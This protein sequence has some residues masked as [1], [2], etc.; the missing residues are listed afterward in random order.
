MTLLGKSDDEV[1]QLENQLMS[2]L[3]A[4]GGV[5]VGNVT[6][7]RELSWLDE[8]YW[9]VR[10]RLVDQ[11][12][13]QRGHGRGGSV[14]VV[15]AADAAAPPQEPTGPAALSEDALYDPIA[16]VLNEDWARDSRFQQHLVQVT[17]KQGRKKTGGT[18]TRPDIIVAALRVFPYLPGKYFDLIS[19]E[20]K[21]SWGVDVTAVYE[22]LAHR[23]ASTQAYTWFHVPDASAESL[24]EAVEAICA[25]A[26]RHGVGVIVASEPGDYSTWD[27]MVDADRVPP[28]PESTNELVSQLNEAARASLALWAR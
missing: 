9:P 10:D 28:D 7:R 2:K 13:I 8:L 20:V 24:A 1:K 5:A 21:P 27:I 17:A 14:S 4:L 16:K 19:F 22:A 15:A 6:L 25:E 12:R 26:K 3:A 23:R 18:W 11:G